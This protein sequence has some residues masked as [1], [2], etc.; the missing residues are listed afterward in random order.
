MLEGCGGGTIDIKTSIGT[1]LGFLK[2]IESYLSAIRVAI[3]T[4]GVE[5]TIETTLH[6]PL[7]LLPDKRC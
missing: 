5:I 6:T 1:Y 2:L 7:L 4:E 3:M